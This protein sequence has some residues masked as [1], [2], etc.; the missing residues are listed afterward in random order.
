[1]TET[2]DLLSSFRME[3]IIALS[4]EHGEDGDTRL[5]PLDK[6]TLGLNTGWWIFNA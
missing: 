3:P 2:T 4:G 6:I 1:M 5:A